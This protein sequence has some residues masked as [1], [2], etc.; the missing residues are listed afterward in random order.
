MLVQKVYCIGNDK[1]HLKLLLSKDGVSYLEPSAAD[2]FPVWRGATGAA[3]R[4]AFEHGAEY[5]ELRAEYRRCV[6]FLRSQR[7]AANE[8]LASLDR[9]LAFVAQKRRDFESAKQFFTKSTLLS[10]ADGRQFL[11]CIHI[12]IV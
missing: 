10:L 6:R 5:E 9:K 8:T 3:R 11:F 2:A 7:L 12:V 1:Q 4:F